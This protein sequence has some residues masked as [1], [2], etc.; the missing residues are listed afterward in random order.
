MLPI[1]GAFDVI[2]VP[3]HC[4][5]QVALLWRPGRMLFAADVCTNIMGLGDPVG[6]ENLE[7]GRVSQRKLASLSFDAAGFGHGKRRRVFE[8]S[9]ANI[10]RKCINFDPQ[11][12]APTE[13]AGWSTGFV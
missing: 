5:G 12:N 13:G 6:F 4:A 10:Q 1:A 2:H 3:G 9:T 7:E 8:A 11:L